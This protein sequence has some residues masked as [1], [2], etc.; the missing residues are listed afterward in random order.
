MKKSIGYGRGSVYT[1]ILKALQSGDKYGYEICKEIEEKSKGA[2]ILKQPSL[3]SGLKRLEAQKDVYSYWGDSD[4][5]G[6]RHYYSLTEKGRER[7]ARTNFSWEDARADVLSD[8]FELSEEEK[9][10]NILKKD[11]ENVSSDIQDITNINEKL[12]AQIDKNDTNIQDIAASNNLQST[13]NTDDLISFKNYKPVQENV[14]SNQNVVKI[15]RHNVDENQQDLF[16]L[17]SY[18]TNNFNITKDDES[19]GVI[20]QENQDNAEK[21]ILQEENE[22]NILKVES[23]VENDVLSVEDNEISNKNQ[24]TDQSLTNNEI[25][26]SLDKNDTLISNPI[27]SQQEVE[28]KIVDNEIIINNKENNDVVKTKKVEKSVINV[29]EYLNSKK[30]TTLFDEEIQRPPLRIENQEN[31]MIDTQKE[32]NQSSVFDDEQEKRYQDF[33]K[34]FEVDDKENEKDNSNIDEN[35]E[36]SQNLTKNIENP[37]ILSNNLDSSLESV[38]NAVSHTQNQ[39]VFY[40]MNEENSQNVNNTASNVKAENAVFNEDFELVNNQTSSNE[41]IKQEESSSIIYTTPLSQQATEFNNINFTTKEIEKT[42]SENNKETTN[43]INQQPTSASSSLYQD[44]HETNEFQSNLINNQNSIKVKEIF[45]DLIEDVPQVDEQEIQD[46]KN[47]I[48]SA[49]KENDEF[50]TNETKQLFEDYNKT[51]FKAKDDLPRVDMS[52]NINLTLKTDGYEEPQKV[53]KSPFKSYHD[54]EPSKDDIYDKMYEKAYQ[55]RYEK[56]NYNI[57]TTYNSIEE[58]H[59][60]N[61]IN[62]SYNIRP[63]YIEST[64]FDKK[65]EMLHP[66]SLQEED[67]VV[68]RYNNVDVSNVESKYFNV[69]KFKSIN[70]FIN[71]I[72][73]LISSILINVIAFNL[74]F[75]SA[76]QQSFLIAEYCVIGAYIILSIVNNVLH[77][78]Q[79]KIKTKSISKINILVLIILLVAVITLNLLLLN[80]YGNLFKYYST[81]LIPSVVCVLMIIS[82]VIM[83]KIENCSFLYK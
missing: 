24:E 10:V 61:T 82:N 46:Y 37:N 48:L 4:I 15:E 59:T 50:T 39:V 72:I 34:A 16:S 55:E 8:L 11:V 65:Y 13:E 38:N 51:N 45:G 74:E 5:G 66:S 2:Y 12:Q 41:E 1:I 30:T 17:F 3:Y 68:R 18:S 49:N 69:S 62:N 53:Y 57:D 54:D 79:R 81:L 26:E 32:E 44:N 22:N 31:T 43:Y 9:T 63:T 80:I 77:K 27:L 58:K 60:E 71:I 19:I 35:L 28:N 52:N 70:N 14:Q 47:S 73:M 33:L 29:Q 78:N 25:T 36:T 64:P 7:I 56:T 75:V 40:N 20:V 76:L 6:R 23:K 21:N 42:E 83:I 67:Y